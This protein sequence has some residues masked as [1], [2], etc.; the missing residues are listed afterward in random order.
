MGRKLKLGERVAFPGDPTDLGTVVE[1]SH[2]RSP[3]PGVGTKIVS[4]I[5][6]DRGQGEVRDIDQCT[7]YG[8]L[9]LNGKPVIR[10]SAR[11]SPERARK[12]YE[13]AQQTW[14]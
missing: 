4:I 11:R 14:K 3:K 6:W 12:E 1:H 2:I 7:I 8:V 9:E 10:T 5:L 13:E